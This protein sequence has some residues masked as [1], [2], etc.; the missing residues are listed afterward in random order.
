MIHWHFIP[1]RAPNF[2]GL[3]EAAVKSAKHH[4]KRIVGDAHLTFEEL[5]TVIT[6]IEAIMNSRPLIPMSNDPNDMDVLTPGHFLIG[7]PLTTVPQSSVVELPTNRLNQY[8]RLQQ[9]IQHFWSR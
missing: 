3:W 5:Y 1:P 4:I 8:Q 7:E 9:L 6:Q 2:V